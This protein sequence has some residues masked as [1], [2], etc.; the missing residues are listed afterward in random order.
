MEKGLEPIEQESPER[1]RI[2]SYP[3]MVSIVVFL[4][5]LFGCAAQKDVQ[6]GRAAIASA[7]PLATEAGFEILTQ[8]GN[9][10]DAAVA[11]AATLAVVEPYSSGLG[12]GGFFLLYR[13]HDRAEIFID[14]RE[15]APKAA[16]ADMYE[17]DQRASLDGALAAAIPGI[18][19]ALDWL[20]QRHGK[21]A[22]AQN[23]APAFRY[24]ARGFGVDQRYAN[25]AKSQQERLGGSVFLDEGEAPEAGFVL[26]QPRLANTLRTVAYQGR[27]G[28]YR[29]KIARE[30]VDSVREAGGI[31]S[32]D[33]LAQYEVIEREPL[34]FKYRDLAITAAPLPSSAGIAL[35][36]SLAIL[37]YFP[38]E[39]LRE[40]EQA[41]LI[42]EAM[43]R[44]FEDRAEYL[45]SSSEIPV[46]RLLKPSYARARAATIDKDRATPSAELDAARPRGEHT[47]HFSIVDREGNRVAAT[48]TINTAFGSGFIAGSTGVLL[49]NEMDDFATEPG[50]P[51]FYGLITGEANAIQ[52]G[53]RPL[54]S[55]APTF[56]EDDRGLLIAGTPGGPR[57]ISQMLLAI[58]DFA[59]QRDLEF[60]VSRPRY[61]HQYLPDWIAIEPD[62]FSEDWKQSL[63]RKGHTVR[64]GKR[65]WGNM[66]AVFLDKRSGKV[67]AKSDPRGRSE[68]GF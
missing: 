19:A 2:S 13:A 32:V 55:M 18:P 57:I 16:T 22:L 35:A 64:T 9:A 41:H 28:F 31:W 4:L 68:V 38:L 5:A 42:V 10:F 26:R 14:A 58:L 47:T 17:G 7:H 51:N 54:S 37:E 59:H 30:L 1:E 34:K 50:K 23:F 21:L 62:G 53:K 49:N 25:A 67:S 63:E 61:H 43:R 20:T 15:T 6:P 56:I 65:R 52:P 3:A 33:D 46:A 45:G 12:G 36:Q 44:A 29:G 39:T 24:A 66:Q 60:I 48:L 27:D 11:V 8:G 40:S